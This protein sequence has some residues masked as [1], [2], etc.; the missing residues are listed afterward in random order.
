VRGIDVARKITFVDWYPGAR[1]THITIESRP[2]GRAELTII[3]APLYLPDQHGRPPSLN[4]GSM[5]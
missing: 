1:T 5:P 2:V 3:E 4:G